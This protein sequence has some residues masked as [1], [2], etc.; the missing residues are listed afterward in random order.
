[1]ACAHHMPCPQQVVTESQK[2]QRSEMDKSSI[3]SY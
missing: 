3:H 1:M 2:E